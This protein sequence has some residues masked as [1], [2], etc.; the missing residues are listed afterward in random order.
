MIV[1]KEDDQI[2]CSTELILKGEIKWKELVDLRTHLEK[3]EFEKCNNEPK[4]IKILFA[5]ILG[6]TRLKAM[7]FDRAFNVYKEYSTGIK[8]LKNGYS[9][10]YSLKEVK[11]ILD[12]NSFFEIGPSKYLDEKKYT[13][14]S[15]R[16]YVNEILSNRLSVTFNSK[17]YIEYADKKNIKI[18]NVEKLFVNQAMVDVLLNEMKA[19]R[20]KN[21]IDALDECTNHKDYIENFFLFDDGKKARV[22]SFFLKEL[23]KIELLKY[24][25]MKI[26]KASVD[27]IYKYASCNQKIFDIVKLTDPT[28]SKEFKNM[29]V[30]INKEVENRNEITLEN[31]LFFKIVKGY[32][33]NKLGNIYLD[34][35]CHDIELK[36]LF[37]YVKFSKLLCISTL[38]EFGLN[39]E[40]AETISERLKKIKNI[41]RKELKKRLAYFYYCWVNEVDEQE[42]LYYGL[43]QSISMLE[44][45]ENK[46]VFIYDKNNNIFNEDGIEVFCSIHENYFSAY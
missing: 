18:N 45:K 9:L 17:A 2:E 20:S 16:Q 7:T 6:E 32:R 5:N 11:Y 1:I 4:N 13:I 31:Q 38:K 44:W 29:Y 24:E 27:I 3:H 19:Y 21:W 28:S 8:Y 22:N 39:N 30:K 35:R 10:W 40:D 15:I 36:K 12:G 14:E 46:V 23:N 34:S 37:S 33:I 25:L 42:K 43:E 41:A 26:E